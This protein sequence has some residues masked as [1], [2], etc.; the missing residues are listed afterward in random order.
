MKVSVGCRWSVSA[1][2]PTPPTPIDETDGPS[3]Q[4]RTGRQNKTAKGGKNG[5]RFRADFRWFVI[6]GL[7]VAFAKRLRR[8]GW[9]MRPG[10]GKRTATPRQR[11]N[12]QIGKWRSRACLWALFAD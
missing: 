3:R 10:S 5:V 1:S 4:E 2:L 9:P 12:R 6:A 11:T 8:L 7:A